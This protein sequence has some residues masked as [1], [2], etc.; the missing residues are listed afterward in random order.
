MTL[1]DHEEL[2]AKMTSDAGR[3][4]PL[5]DA[6]QKLSGASYASEIARYPV[7]LQA[8]SYFLANTLVTMNAAQLR[9]PSSPTAL[10]QS[11]VCY[12]L[13]QASTSSRRR[14]S[15]LISAR[16]FARRSCRHAFSIAHTSFSSLQ[17]L[18]LA[19]SLLVC[20]LKVRFPFYWRR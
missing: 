16:P 5:K 11:N 9:Y 2:Y 13:S 12:T 6:S 17:T 3:S 10:L 20:M 8:Q 7:S 1:G 15:S 18:L 19:F 4:I 14:P